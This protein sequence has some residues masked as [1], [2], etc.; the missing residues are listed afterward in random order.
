M[1]QSEKLSINLITNTKINILYHISHQLGSQFSQ[2]K[3]K[4]RTPLVELEPSL[5]FVLIQLLYGISTHSSCHAFI[6]EYT[7]TSNNGNEISTLN[8]IHILKALSFSQ[9]PLTRYYSFLIWS[10]LLTL[11][12]YRSASSTS[13][14]A[15]SSMH[16]DSKL[17]DNRYTRYLCRNEQVLNLLMYAFKEETEMI[18]KRMITLLL[19]DI[20]SIR[21]NNYERIIILEHF[22]LLF[23]SID[24]LHF[25][26]SY[27]MDVYETRNGIFNEEES[28]TVDQSV[29]LSI[30]QIHL[31]TTIVRMDSEV[32]SNE[33]SGTSPTLELLKTQ[34]QIQRYIS[35]LLLVLDKRGDAKNANTIRALATSVLQLEL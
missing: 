24:L 20:C 8:I 17:F 13:S 26:M 2:Q 16:T 7:T 5:Q 1:I 19:K 22:N 14:T 33:T 11:S 28:V 23:E 34:Y 12:S 32:T 4:E 15:S 10:N 30:A 18:I 25:Q 29:Q 6:I 35:D 21:Q 9:Y 31:I 3:S 27:L